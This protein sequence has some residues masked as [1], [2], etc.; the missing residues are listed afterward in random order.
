MSHVQFLARKT[1][2]KIFKNL[3]KEMNEDVHNIQIG[4]CY[5]NSQQVYEAYRHFKKEKDIELGNYVG[6][7]IDW[8]GGTSMI[9]ATIAQAGITYQN[10]FKCA[11]EDLNV[12]MKH[13]E[14]YF[15]VA[16]LLLKGKK[17]KEINIET[18]FFQ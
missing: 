6:T 15:P 10:Q 17:E 14:G 9:D 12:I 18:E 2:D 11:S 7:I 5:K 8:S 13:N 3:A 16:V 4:I 1:F